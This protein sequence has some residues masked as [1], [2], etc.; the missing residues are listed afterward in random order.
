MKSTA[1]IVSLLILFSAFV[2]GQPPDDKS[3]VTIGGEVWASGG[4][5]WE[6]DNWAPLQSPTNAFQYIRLN[7]SLW[8]RAIPSDIVSAFGRISFA[9]EGK[10]NT[11]IVDIT[12]FT[13]ILS[14]SFQIDSLYVTISPSPYLN[15]TGGKRS[16]GWE[17]GRFFSPADYINSER[18]N[19]LDPGLVPAGVFALTAEVPVGRQHFIMNLLMTNNERPWDIEIAPQV[20]LNIGPIEARLGGKFQYNGPIYGSIGLTTDILIFRPFAEA[21]V[22]FY[23]DRNY[24]DSTEEEVWPAG[25]TVEQAP[26]ALVFELTGGMEISVEDIGIDAYVQYLYN[27]WGEF[28]GD[29][30]PVLYSSSVDILL[31]EDRISAS[32][33]FLPGQHY[34]ALALD[35]EI[36][37]T[38]LHVDTSWLINLQALSYGLDLTLAYRP[39]PFIDIALNVP[40]ALHDYL[41][42]F[43]DFQ[44]GWRADFSVTLGTS[45]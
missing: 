17:L 45:F 7:S 4:I 12:G 36:F 30:F 23:S 6:W 10:N 26:E 3:P 15:L 31:Q 19:Y 40:I 5:A 44:N 13:E 34:L 8:I 20:L 39:L 11:E 1:I 24:I 2:F 28:Y 42:E 18:L 33:L 35:W 29:N 21:G 16:L 25:V 27:S 43:N 38:G 41:M 22:E 9:Y 37:N 14:E 32:D